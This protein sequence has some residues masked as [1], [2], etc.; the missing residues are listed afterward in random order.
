MIDHACQKCRGE[1]DRWP[2]GYCQSCH[3]EQERRDAAYEDALR[4]SDY[5]SWMA[6]RMMRNG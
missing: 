4:Q 5:L 6:R 1:N 3:V 2:Y